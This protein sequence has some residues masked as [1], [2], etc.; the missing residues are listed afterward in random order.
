MLYIFLNMNNILIV[1]S[2]L[3]LLDVGLGEGAFVGDHVGIRVG[4]D[5]TAVRGGVTYLTAY[6]R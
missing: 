2:R 5:G 3:Y 4:P 1:S 6:D